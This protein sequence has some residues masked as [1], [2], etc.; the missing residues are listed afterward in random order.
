M[1]IRVASSALK[2][3]MAFLKPEV[4]RSSGFYPDV[5]LLTAC[6]AIRNFVHCGTAASFMTPWHPT[7]LQNARQLQKRLLEPL[8]RLHSPVRHHTVTFNMELQMNS[9]LEKEA[10]HCAQPQKALASK[11]LNL[12]ALGWPISFNHY[13][14]GVVEDTNERPGCH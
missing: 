8:F 5:T 6:S 2:S 9:R 7:V 10:W 11:I 3:S 1:C 12:K 4:L 14:T 13:Q